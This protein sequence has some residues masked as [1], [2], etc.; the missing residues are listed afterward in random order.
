MT[1]TKTTNKEIHER[2]TAKFENLKWKVQSTY[3]NDT[4]C[5]CVPYIDARDVIDRLDEVM[6]FDKWQDSVV[7]T[8]GT[9]TCSIS[10][11]LDWEWVS[12][13]DTGDWKDDKASS[14]WA[15]KRAWAKRGIGRYIYDIN[16]VF[17]KYQKNGKYWDPIN[18]KWEKIKDL[19]KHINALFSNNL[20]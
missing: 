20:K 10:L 11:L 4:W 13:S 18:D 1:N 8:A 7:A 5:I 16:P 9:I 12:K 19:S 3:A 2:L 15:F 17:L 14:S 6:G